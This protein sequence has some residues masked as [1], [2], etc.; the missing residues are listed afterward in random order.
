[1]WPGSSSRNIFYPSSLLR[2]LSW[3]TEAER[4]TAAR[5]TFEDLLRLASDEVLVSTFALENDSI[6]RPSPFI[7]DLATAGLPVGR[8]AQGQAHAQAQGHARA[9]DDSSLMTVPAIESDSGNDR[10]SDGDRATAG[11]AGESEA[12]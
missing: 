11:A 4:R 6:V 8:I 9:L 10:D 12:S 7:E 1:E 3:P 5:A 2:E